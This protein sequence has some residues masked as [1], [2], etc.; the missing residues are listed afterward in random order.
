MNA[1]SCPG[2]GTGSLL[3]PLPPPLLSL[4]QLR[5]YLG[6]LAAGQAEGSVTE[7]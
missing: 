6:L 7:V 1:R 4:S 5:E 2:S 3:L